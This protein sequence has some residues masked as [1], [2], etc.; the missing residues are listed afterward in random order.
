MATSSAAAQ[1][2]PD[3]RA[4]VSARPFSNIL[5]AVDG[6]EGGFAAVE[7]AAAISG[8]ECHLTVLVV[9]SYRKA[10]EYRSPSIGPLEAKRIVDRARAIAE[11]AGVSVTVVVEP[12]SPPARVVL[13]W[14]GQHDLLAMGAPAASWLGGMLIAGVADSALRSFVTPLLVARANDSDQRVYQHVLVASDGLEDSEQPV[15]MAGAIARAYGSKV[16]LVHALGRAHERARER[17]L[18]QGHAMELATADAPDLLLRR[19]SAH[20]VIL[21]SVEEIGPSLV[22]V[23]SRRRAGVRAIGSVGRRVVH[24]ATRSVLLVAPG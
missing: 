22:L 4:G 10:G 2:Q 6:K 12:A 11:R 3:A 21:R 24:D 9:T 17:V 8:R 19:G 7:Q 1:T 15:E 14:A 18:A 13:E 20:E 16:T 23:G 5:C